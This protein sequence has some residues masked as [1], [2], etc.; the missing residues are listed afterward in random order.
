MYQNTTG[1]NNTAVGVAALYTSMD[2]SCLVAIGDSALYWNALGSSDPFEG[3]RN[4][5]IGSKSLYANTTGSY[6][7][8]VGYET[9]LANVNGAV[10]TAM[11]Y[12]ALYQNT[13]GYYNTAL[14]AETLTSNTSGYNNTAVGHASLIT[15]TSGDFNTA[16][17]SS[18]LFSNASGQQNVA[19]GH[20][21]GYQ[22]LSSDNVFV[23]AYAG[24]S[25]A[26][27]TSVLYIGHEAGRNTIGS[28]NLFV[29]SSAGR[30]SAASS[31]LMIGQRA[32]EL[33][34]TSEHLLLIGHQAGREVQSQGVIVVTP[35]GESYHGADENVFIG[36]NAGMQTR[37]G[38]NTFVGFKAGEW[39]N[40]GAAGGN[41]LVGHKAGRNGA[42]TSQ[43]TFI[44]TQAG[45]GLIEGWG[46]A[47]LGMLAGASPEKGTY[48]TWVGTATAQSMTY[49]D[50]NIF[51]G[52]NATSSVDSVQHA[53]AIGTFAYVSC[54]TCI[55]LGNPNAQHRVGINLPAPFARLQVPQTGSLNNGGLDVTNAAIYIG[56]TQT[57]GMAFDENQI[58]SVGDD[59]YLN[60]N[61]DGDVRLV[62]GGGKVGV[63]IS[64]SPQSSLHVKQLSSFS[65]GGIRL[66]YNTDTD[67]WETW[68][69]VANDYNFAFNGTLKA[70]IQDT[71]GAY[72]STS[73]RRLKQD[74]HPVDHVLHRMRQLQPSTYRFR[75]ADSNARSTGLIAQEV[76]PFFP[77][78]VVEKDG[79]LG[80]NYQGLGVMTIRAVQ[81]LADRQDAMQ[82]EIDRLVEVNRELETQLHDL[83][84]TVATLKR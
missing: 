48:N 54:D 11:G 82:D 45:H 46:N 18:A 77:D 28:D 84:T 37:S 38:G 13:D 67:F 73:D 14:G 42:F 9:L 78:L 31:N 49:G 66:E 83:M 74:I 43:N 76:Q 19:I 12:W 41:T 25:S 20:R 70:Y 21:S 23:G 65:D 32:G 2:R 8:A 15:N 36:E 17:G 16:V 79:L 81:E 27:D 47:S 35:T 57:Q 61:S 7:T 22:N 60:F 55:A 64:T 5:A 62:E 4:T 51:L 1:S 68:I 63:N 24:E 71:D 40:M 6:N 3:R 72:V 69:D 33:T 29:G 59:L 75:A 26:S 52:A 30:Q 80:V 53:M 56:E 58:E 44:G 10:N 34:D 50:Y 39:L